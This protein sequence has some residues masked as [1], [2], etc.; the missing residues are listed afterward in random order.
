MNRAAKYGVEFNSTQKKVKEE[1]HRH[2]TQR[3]QL[4]KNL[5]QIMASISLK[6]A[7]S[8]NASVFS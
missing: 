2:A 3:S 4:T 7:S 8:S 5:I 1:R 6:D